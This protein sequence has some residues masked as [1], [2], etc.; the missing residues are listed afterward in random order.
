MSTAVRAGLGVGIAVFVLVLPGALVRATY[1]AQTTADEPQYLL[2]AISIAEDW[3]LDI[4]DERYEGRYRE[5]HEA[6][7]PVQTPSAVGLERRL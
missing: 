5:F 7:L 3:S 6:N 2:T 1:G 4:S